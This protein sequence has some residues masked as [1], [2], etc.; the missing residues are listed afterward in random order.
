MTVRA[1][2][3]LLPG[4]NITYV[5]KN[6]ISQLSTA[7]DENMVTFID[8]NQ[9][10]SGSSILVT[11]KGSS[12]TNI[13]AYIDVQQGAKINAFL[14]E[15]GQNRATID[16]SGRLKYTLDFA[17]KDNLTGTY[18]ITSGNVRYT[19][20]LI[21]QKNFDITNGSTISWT[22]EML[23]P[24]LNLK[25][26]ERIKSSVQGEKEPV[27]FLIDAHVGGTLSNIE[28]DFDLTSETNTSVQNELQSMSDNQRSQ[29]AINLLLFN[30]Y[31]GT[32][33][34]GLISDQTGTS[35]L[36]SFLQSKLNAWAAQTLPG[37]DLSFGINQYRGAQSGTETS[38]SYRLAKTLFNDRF[39]IVVGGEYS[40]VAA[41]EEH[42]ADKLF[43]DVSLEYYLN[44]NATRYLK[45]FRH[46]SYENV[47]EGQVT[48]TGVAY[49]LKRKL[50]NLRNL[51]TFKHSREYLIKDSLE[52]A[53][54]AALKLQE[55]AIEAITSDDETYTV[56]LD[57]GQ[58]IDKPTVTRKRDENE[59]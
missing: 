23:N 55:K 4:S 44:D 43:N 3:T 54:K 38:Y 2:A 6:D 12:A 36:F 35:A 9:P 52:K 22:G 11:G 39:K 1:D 47:L 17:G 24:Q 59:E 33:S 34:P 56:P 46:L 7:V 49:V 50:T 31:S 40:T 58:A 15:D 57:N 48:E 13:L 26:T 20:P 45:L 51:F 16:G 37:I 29:A 27:E 10:T 42:V 53:R 41:E 5:M 8:F 32:N 18:T 30:T 28:L 25:G 21:S 19:P 14:S